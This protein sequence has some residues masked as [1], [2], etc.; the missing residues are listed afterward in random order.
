MP[1]HAARRISVNRGDGIGA[2]SRAVRD[3]TVRI[4]LDV[5]LQVVE[6]DRRILSHSGGE[7]EIP[8]LLSG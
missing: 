2:A 5:G 6:R 4:Q 7:L 3:V 1:S 8:R